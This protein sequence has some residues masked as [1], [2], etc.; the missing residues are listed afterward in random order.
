MPDHVRYANPPVTCESATCKISYGL[1]PVIGNITS[2]AM[3]VARVLPTLTATATTSIRK[4]LFES[5]SRTDEALVI[6]E[7]SSVLG[8]RLAASISPAITP[9]LRNG[10]GTKGL[11]PAYP[12]DA[13]MASGWLLLAVAKLAAK[14][15]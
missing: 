5:S 1:T 12:A 10:S 15:A 9:T 8:G 7:K 13:A 2:R 3:S 11:K 14:T 6:P 4:S